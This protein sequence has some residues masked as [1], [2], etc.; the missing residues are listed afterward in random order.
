MKNSEEEYPNVVI[1]YSKLGTLTTGVY[2]LFVEN[3]FLA[4][5]YPREPT[6][7]QTRSSRVTYAG[8]IAAAVNGHSPSKHIVEI[9]CSAGVRCSI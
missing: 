5:L 4:A 3:V 9:N 8:Y 1:T 6:W 2:A 7:P